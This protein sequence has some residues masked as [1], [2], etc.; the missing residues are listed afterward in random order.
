[1]IDM[2][3]LLTDTKLNLAYRATMVFKEGIRYGIRSSKNEKIG[4][5]VRWAGELV[6]RY[7]FTWSFILKRFSC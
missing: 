7:P 5:M 1:M 4:G 3:I 2:P 6:A